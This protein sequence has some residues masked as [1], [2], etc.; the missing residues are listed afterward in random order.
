MVRN[1]LD[2]QTTDIPIS[3]IYRTNIRFDASSYDTAG[4]EAKK[5]IKNS[6]L[7]LASISEISENCFYPKRFKRNFVKK[8]SPKAIGFIGSSEMLDIN[9]VPRK[10]LSEHL[11]DTASLKVNE[12]DVLISRSGTIGNISIINKTLSQFL[13]SEHSIRIQSKNY[14]S[15]IAIFLKSEIGQAIL[16]SKIFGSVVNQIEPEDINDIKLPIPD[17]NILARIH[18]LVTESNNLIDTS[19]KLEDNAHKKLL[20]ALDIENNLIETQELTT[21]SVKLKDLNYRFDASYHNPVINSI[22]EKW[23]TNPCIDK[24][25]TLKNLSSEIILPGRF[26]R[27]YVDKDHGALFIGGKQIWQLDPNNKKYLSLHFHKERI[28]QQLTLKEN[29]ILV[30]CSGTIG[31]VAFVPKHWEGWTANQHIMRINTANEMMAAYIYQFLRSEVGKCFILKHTYGSVV[32][33]IDDRHLAEV[34]IPILTS[35]SLI[36]EISNDTLKS[37]ELRSKAY[38]LQQEAMDIFNTKVITKPFS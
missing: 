9:P 33:E 25:I 20:R 21:Q 8:N 7:S 13:F 6:G 1:K 36:E 5:I 38:F 34:E 35:Q 22:M 16:K 15:Y 17:K 10:F 26:K 14:S 18:E 4:S 2:L 29:M 12:H 30:T 3:Q 31:K 32:D 23:S 24:V 37:K 27:T 19:N 28:Q 11:T